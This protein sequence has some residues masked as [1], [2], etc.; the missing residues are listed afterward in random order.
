[1]NARKPGN[2]STRKPDGKSPRPKGGVLNLLP[3]VQFL[4]ELH[5]ARLEL[6]SFAPR[7]RILNDFRAFAVE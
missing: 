3:N 6:E 1:M 7:A 5:L 2:L 4:Y